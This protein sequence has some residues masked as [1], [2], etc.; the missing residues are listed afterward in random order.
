MSVAV[1]AACRL[2]DALVAGGV[3]HFCV[4]PGNRSA[5]L[6]F[7]LSG[8][9]GASVSVH[10]DERAAGFWAL[11]RARESNTPV[12]LVCTSGSAVANLMPA[13]VEAAAQDVALVLLT[14]DR[15]AELHGIGAD[16]T[17]EQASIFAPYA[18]WRRDVEAPAG[19]AFEAALLDRIAHEALRA[20]SAGPVHLNLRYRDPL[21]PPVGWTRPEPRRAGVAAS[22]GVPASQAV[23]G[24]TGA[25]VSVGLSALLAESRR[26]LVVVGPLA[27]GHEAVLACAEALDAPIVADG[28]SGLRVAGAPRVVSTADATLRDSTAPTPDLF[29]RFG[30]TPTS[31]TV[32]EWVDAAARS[33]GARHV[34]VRPGARLADAGLTVHDDIDPAALL[35]A[36]GATPRV[37]RGAWTE[38]WLRADAAARAV[39]DADAAAGALPDEAAA[40]DAT[41]AA[42]ADG[43]ALHVASSMPVRDLELCARALPPGVRVA[44]NRGL[45]GIDGT[46]STAL[47]RASVTPGR[48]FV[49][50]G[51][52][53]FLHDATALVA[54]RDARL[55]VVVVNNGGGGIFGFL[56]VALHADVHERF[57]VTAQDFDV[58]A[59]CAAF[60]VAHQRVTPRDSAEAIAGTRRLAGPA[61]IEVACGR[62]ASRDG[63]RALW[64]RMAAAARGEFAGVGR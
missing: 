5:P 58:S 19:L 39:L 33:T 30:S 27:Q 62:E 52:L 44:A 4:C 36:I 9:G 23:A 24:V 63:H 37:D 60:G 51:D 54:A 17:M 20:A 35:A 38:T 55:T 56:P 18:A 22:A 47:G 59:L 43:D 42:L 1:E 41:L 45:N 61:C 53:A 15:P 46:L 10:I 2:V 14:A 34:L 57:F 28:L 16:Q 50:L 49:V 6:A 32:R 12:A 29:V 13:V 26:P 40:M 21:T 25:A 3:S 64:S 48:T 7:A 8:L 11:G 31:R